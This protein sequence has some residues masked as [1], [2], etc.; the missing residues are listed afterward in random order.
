VHRRKP[1]SHATGECKTTPIAPP[2][3][4]LG[5]DARRHLV[6]EIVLMGIGV[7]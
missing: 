6:Y 3:P 5:A 7:L 1:I 2:N 4:V